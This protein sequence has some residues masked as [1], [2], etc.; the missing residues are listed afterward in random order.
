MRKKV[1]TPILWTTSLP[2]SAIF[3]YSQIPTFDD[4]FLTIAPM[5]Y[6]INKNKLMWQSYFFICWRLKNVTG[7]FI[8]STFVSNSRLMIWSEIITVLSIKRSQK[9]NKHSERKTY[10][11]KCISATKSIHYQLKALPTPPFHGQPLLYGLPRIFT[12]KSWSFPSMIFQKSQL[13]YK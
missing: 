11:V 13:P 12:R 4:N 7:F 6:G 3:S 10:W 2:P 8:S 5:K 9:K 1:W